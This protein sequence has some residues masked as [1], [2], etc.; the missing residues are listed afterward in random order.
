M[1]ATLSPRI[2]PASHGPYFL[3]SWSAESVPKVLCMQVH[4]C[5]TERHAQPR[6]RCL[7]LNRG[8][9]EPL[10]IGYGSQAFSGAESLGKA[11]LEAK[12]GQ[13]KHRQ[14]AMQAYVAWDIA[15]INQMA[16]EDDHRLWVMTD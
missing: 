14:E 10:R 1:N 13:S 3:I 4:L 8:Q 7:R 9:G 12:G 11:G 6:G 15:L 5:G 2:T 16:T